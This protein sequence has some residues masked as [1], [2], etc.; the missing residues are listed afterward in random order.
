MNIYPHKV[1]VVL[2][3]IFITSV[4][5]LN[6]QNVFTEKLNKTA[7]LSLENNSGFTLDSAYYLKPNNKI[8]N[9]VPPVYPGLRKDDILFSETVWEDING[10]EKKIDFYYMTKKMK[11]DLVNFLT[12]LRIFY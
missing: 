9:R 12:Y 10:K 7:V 1:K 11:Q 6:A 4:S 2:F 3:L 5:S 8:N